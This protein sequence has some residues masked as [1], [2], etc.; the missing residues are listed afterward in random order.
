MTAKEEGREGLDTLLAAFDLPCDDSSRKLFR[1]NS[2]RCIGGSG[3]GC[4][5][6]RLRL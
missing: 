5:R 6:G 2:F 4:L 3:F 1:V